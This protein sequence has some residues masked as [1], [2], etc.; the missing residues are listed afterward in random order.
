[1]AKVYWF[2][3]MLRHYGALQ[4]YYYYYY[5]YYQGMYMRIN[6]SNISGS[7]YFGTLCCC[8]SG[9]GYVVW[10]VCCLIFM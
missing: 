6:V 2:G 4:M 10:Q 9:D 1:M 7:W 5:Y 3:P 8:W